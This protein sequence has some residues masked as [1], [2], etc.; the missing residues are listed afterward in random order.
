MWFKTEKIIL[1]PHHRRSSSPGL[2]ESLNDRA[3]QFAAG[4]EYDLLDA[5]FTEPA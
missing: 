2:P 1:R 4:L 3:L 5:Y